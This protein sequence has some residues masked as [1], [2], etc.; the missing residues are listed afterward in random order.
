VFERMLA[1]RSDDSLRQRL[2]LRASLAEAW[3]FTRT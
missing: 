1:L 3:R 2:L